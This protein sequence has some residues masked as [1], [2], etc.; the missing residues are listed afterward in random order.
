MGAWES[1]SVAAVIFPTGGT[2]A[3]VRRLDAAQVWPF[4]IALSTPK[5]RLLSTA[6]DIDRCS[7]GWLP[8]ALNFANGRAD[9]F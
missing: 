4:L 1:D 9:A 7:Q 6:T 5:C 3:D 2:L 8:R